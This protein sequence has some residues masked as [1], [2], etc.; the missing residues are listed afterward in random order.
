VEWFYAVNDDRRGPISDGE[1]EVLISNGTIRPGTL[2]WRQG[3]AD[4]LPY[5]AL[6]GGAPNY[7]GEI[8][9]RY[10]GFWIRFAAKVID[11][12]ILNIA[13]FVVGFVAGFAGALVLDDDS[14]LALNIFIYTVAILM[15]LMYYTLFVGAY[16]ATPGKM[17]LSLQVVRA[18][19]S[20]VSYALAFGRYVAAALNY[21]TLFIGWFMVGWND[22]KRGLHDFICDTRVIRSD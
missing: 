8:G 11:I 7:T 17:A 19:G 5:S 22:E 12:I 18:D 3:M 16:G 20:P 10:A 4:W 21:L 6:S 2:V 9:M 13:G 14:G 15:N 1:F